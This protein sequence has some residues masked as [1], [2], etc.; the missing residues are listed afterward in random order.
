MTMFFIV[1][2]FKNHIIESHHFR[3]K[4]RQPL[5]SFHFGLLVLFSC[6]L[7]CLHWLNAHEHKTYSNN[8]TEEAKIN[9][10]AACKVT[11]PLSVRPPAG[12]SQGFFAT[13]CRIIYLLWLQSASCFERGFFIYIVVVL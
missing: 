5:F 12:K 4:P 7:F 1:G 3:N 10:G 8:K 11:N 13:E 9:Q 6:L 2:R